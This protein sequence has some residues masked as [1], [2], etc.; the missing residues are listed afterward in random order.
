MPSSQFF[1]SQTAC[2]DSTVVKKD[3]ALF[4]VSGFDDGV[5]TLVDLSKTKG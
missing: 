4:L 5:V 3:G 2:A 1:E